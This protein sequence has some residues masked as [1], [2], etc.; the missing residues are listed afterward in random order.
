MKGNSKEQKAS[1]IPRVSP[2]GTSQWWLYCSR[3]I[4]CANHSALRLFLAA[5]DKLKK[6]L[7]QQIRR[8]ASKLWCGLVRS[9]VKKGA[10]SFSGKLSPKSFMRLCLLFRDVGTG[11]HLSEKA[12]QDAI[13]Q[14]PW[15]QHSHLLGA[16]VKGG[17]E[18]WLTTFYMGCFM[19]RSPLRGWNSFCS[20]LHQCVKQTMRW[21][22]HN[23]FCSSGQSTKS[24]SKDRG[25]NLVVE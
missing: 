22:H 10:K 14:R 24:D 3:R 2:V 7:P 9:L 23:C 12:S 15:F 11:F 17:F 19:P 16:Y 20:L 13:V 18:F 1:R 6:R 5:V 4:Y 25:W 8:V 21:K